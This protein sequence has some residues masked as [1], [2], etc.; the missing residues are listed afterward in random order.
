MTPSRPRNRSLNPLKATTARLPRS[1]ERER[2]IFNVTLSIFPTSPEELRSCGGHSAG[3]VDFTRFGVRQPRRTTPN[4]DALKFLNSLLLLPITGCLLLEQTIR[5]SG[6]RFYFRMRCVTAGTSPMKQMWR[7]KT[8]RSGR[9]KKHVCCDKAF[10]QAAKKSAEMMYYVT[11][12][13]RLRR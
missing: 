4:D 10:R 2:D 5:S 7:I 13:G 9:R 1:R 12:S 8:P 3:G 6:A 11:S